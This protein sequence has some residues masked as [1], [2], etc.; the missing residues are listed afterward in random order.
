MFQV[1]YSLPGG[2]APLECRQCHL[3]VLQVLSHCKVL[4]KPPVVA[5]KKADP[6]RQRLEWPTNA[7]RDI[8]AIPGARQ[9][10]S[11]DLHHLQCLRCNV[12]KSVRPGKSLRPRGPNQLTNIAAGTLQGLM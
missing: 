3:T 2:G 9:V 8:A 11:L 12:G 1:L 4:S 5:L 6:L 7:A 10:Q